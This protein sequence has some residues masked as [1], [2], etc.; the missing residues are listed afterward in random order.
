MTLKW[1]EWSHEEGNNMMEWR[2]VAELERFSELR[3]SPL[4]EKLPSFPLIRSFFI[5]LGWRKMTKWSE[6]DQNDRRMQY[7]HWYFL[8]LSFKND[9]EWRNEEEWGGF[10]RERK[11]MN[12]EM[13]VI[14]PS[15]RHPV[16]IQK[17]KHKL[18]TRLSEWL[19]MTGEWPWNERI[20]CCLYKRQ[21][22]I[23]SLRP[24][25]DHS[26]VIQPFLSHSNTKQFY[27]PWNDVRMTEE[28]PR[29]ERIRCCLL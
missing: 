25:L 27:C 16:I 22:P 2:N 12:S 13:S 19:R 11:K 10:R 26:C 28:W 5:I 17:F 23:L 4:F 1:M 8:S 15:F 3:V 18:C 9:M 6:N 24:H 21:H 29:N 14:L 7:S 20:R